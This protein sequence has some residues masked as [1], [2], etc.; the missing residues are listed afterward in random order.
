MPKKPK[1]LQEDELRELV[2]AELGYDCQNYFTDEEVD[3]AG[4]AERLGLKTDV[5]IAEEL[6]RRKEEYEYKRN[7]AAR[8][9]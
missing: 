3:R 2:R 8:A 5:L 7:V 6:E 1:A 4:M 9:R